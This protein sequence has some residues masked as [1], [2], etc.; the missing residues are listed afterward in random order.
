MCPSFLKILVANSV[1]S[2]SFH[3]W[4]ILKSYPFPTDDCLGDGIERCRL[5]HRKS[6]FLS[7]F[8]LKFMEAHLICRSYS[9]D[10]LS[11]GSLEEFEHITKS[12]K[13]NT[14]N[15]EANTYIGA[16][17]LHLLGDPWYW[18]YGKSN[19]FEVV[20]RRT[21][22]SL[23]RWIMCYHCDSWKSNRNKG[24]RMWCVSF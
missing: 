2:V 16:T 7:H 21:E 9:M 18:L 13:A 3:Q 22:Y 24:C 10:L 6:Y 4:N 1:N 23:H 12:M 11:I 17:D 19:G 5:Y 14:S 8:K 20:A 15:F